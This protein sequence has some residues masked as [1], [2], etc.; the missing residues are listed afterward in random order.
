MDSRFLRVV[1]GDLGDVDA[2]ADGTVGRMVED[3]EEVKEEEVDESMEA[4]II[5]TKRYDNSSAPMD[6]SIQMMI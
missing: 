4:S 1:A 6:S 5:L 2:D 3:E